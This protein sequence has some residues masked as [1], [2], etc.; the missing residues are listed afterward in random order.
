M[1]S[2]NVVLVLLSALPTL[3]HGQTAAAK[4]YTPTFGECPSDFTLIRQAGTSNNESIQTLSPSEVGYLQARK[5]DVLPSAWK[6]YLSNAQNVVGVGVP[7]PDY[8]ISILGGNGSATPTLGIATSG[9]GYRAAIFG[10]GILNALDGRDSESV[11]A[12]TGGLLQA[13]TYLTGLSGGSWLVTSLTQANFPPIQELIFGTNT[14][15]DYAGWLPEIGVVTPSNDTTQNE[16]YIG[17]LVEEIKGKHDVGFPVTVGDLWA[18]ALSRHFVN[19]TTTSNFAD[20][21]S[22]HGAGITFSGLANV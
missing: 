6:A 11:K 22:T 15:G 7:L 8:V 5:S 3:V 16:E 10:A 14:S 18:R 12:G 19:G 17:G 1:I 21:S 20:N 2:I 4:A 13:A 9:G